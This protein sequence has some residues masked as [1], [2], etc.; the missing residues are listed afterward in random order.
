MN[1]KE[2]I[3]FIINLSLLILSCV[4]LLFGVFGINDLKLTLLIIFGF[5]AIMKLTQFIFIYKYHDYQS[6][7]TSI[8]SIIACIVIGCLNIKNEYIILTLLIWLGLMCLLK[9]KKADFYHDRGSK[10]WILRIFMLFVFLTISLLTGINLLHGSDI[11]I[12]LIG[13]LFFINSLLEIIDPLV[14]YLIGEDK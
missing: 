9:L 13:Y 12:L 6:L 10:M 7:F 3:D 8:I 14:V 2:I 4:I 1:K 5:H 11:Q